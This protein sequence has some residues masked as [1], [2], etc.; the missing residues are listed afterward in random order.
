MSDN[1]RL[2]QSDDRMR[3]DN[4]RDG[5]MSDGNR[6][7]SNTNDRDDGND[8]E[9]GIYRAISRGYDGGFSRG[10]DSSSS[11][12]DESEH[13]MGD[14]S[15]NSLGGSDAFGRNDDYDHGTYSNQR[16]QGEGTGDLDIR[17]NYGNSQERGRYKQGSQSDYGSGRAG[18]SG[19]S[20]NRNRVNED[21]NEALRHDAHIDASEIEVKA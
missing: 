2:N 7:A 11:N 15:N 12:R 10:R 18:S 20:S 14:R 16:D 5:H 8:R 6:N 13:S 1:N 21:V 17:R 9:Q 19:Q 4:G 3:S